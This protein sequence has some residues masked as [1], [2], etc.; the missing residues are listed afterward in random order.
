MIKKLIKY[1]KKLNQE[2]ELKKITKN[3]IKKITREKENFNL[4]LKL[5]KPDDK[6]R[7]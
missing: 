6:K 7:L 4:N 1:F 2:K 3:T 5:R